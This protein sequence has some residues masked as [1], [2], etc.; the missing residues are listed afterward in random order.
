MDRRDTIAAIATAPGRASIGVVRLSGPAALQISQALCPW[1]QAP[2]DHQARFGKFMNRSGSP[3]DEGLALYFAP[4]RSYTGDEVVELQGHGGLA[5]QLVLQAAVAAG[6]R[7]AEPGEFT[8]RAFCSG[9][10]DLAAAEA[11]GALIAAESE[12]AVR[13]S[14]AVLGG[15]LARR[16]QGLSEATTQV[17]ALLEGTIDFPSE[18]EGAEIEARGALDLLAAD[19][20]E[21]H[22]SHRSARRFQLRSRVVLAGPAN[23][24]KSSL[25]NALVGE[26][27]ALVDEAPGT[28]RDPVERDWELAGAPV[29]LI[30]TAGWR[31]AAGVEAR[32]I[33]KGKAEAE[34]ADLVLWVCDGREA[35]PPPD[36]AWLPVLSKADLWRERGSGIATENAIAISTVEGR[37]LDELQRRMARE[38]VIGQRESSRAVIA[39]RQ[40]HALGESCAR[41]TRAMEYLDAG[42]VEIAAEELGHV[43]E[44]LD[45]VLGRREDPAVIDAVFARFCIGK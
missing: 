10:L 17:R 3:I 14:A 24:G 19:L 13:D 12:T 40:A 33:A 21:L 43:Q 28:T 8:W 22:Q 7:L 30:D 15:E 31:E 26:D 27:C 35:L 9:R 37:G 32:G 2:G 25:L 36:P 44:G 34:A 4:G 18:A 45:R 41:L 6:A 16:I 11:I 38:L 23:A 5:T 39:E 1:L 20:A 42:Q 29:R